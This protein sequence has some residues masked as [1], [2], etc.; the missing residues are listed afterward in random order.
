MSLWGSKYLLHLDMHAFLYNLKFS[1]MN[2]F[3]RFSG[4]VTAC[5]PGLLGVRLCNFPLTVVL[6]C[7]FPSLI[8]HPW[9]SYFQLV[10]SHG[11][12]FLCF[13]FVHWAFS[14]LLVSVFSNL[15]FSCWVFIPLTYFFSHTAWFLISF[16][17]PLFDFL[18]WVLNWIHLLIW[19]LFDVVKHF[20]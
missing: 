14:M 18:L 13:S 17:F 2:L 6:A 3:S 9:S 8:L 15:D 1:T 4:W 10:P 19:I 20:Y 7:Y 5:M 16:T 12:A 11:I